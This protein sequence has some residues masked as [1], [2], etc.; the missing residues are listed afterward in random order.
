LSQTNGH[1]IARPDAQGSVTANTGMMNCSVGSL[2][3]QMDKLP[4]YKRIIIDE[5]FL[6]SLS[7]SF[8]F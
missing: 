1:G 5:G 4:T 6:L 3:V 7:S 2:K 8:G